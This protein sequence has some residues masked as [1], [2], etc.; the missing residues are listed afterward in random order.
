MKVKYTPY[1]QLAEAWMQPGPFAKF[2]RTCVLWQIVKF[3]AYNLK[4]IKVVAKGH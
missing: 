4:I 1:T 2:T 3:A